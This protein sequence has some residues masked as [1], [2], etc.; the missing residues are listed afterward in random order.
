M[1]IQSQGSRFSRQRLEIKEWG[2]P[3]EDCYFFLG[4]VPFL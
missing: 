1:L 4:F 3:L 2:K